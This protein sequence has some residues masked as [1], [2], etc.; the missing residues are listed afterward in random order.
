M[1]NNPLS[2]PKIYCIGSNLESYACLKYL[3]ERDC[4]IHTLITLPSGKAKHVSDYYDLHDY[5]EEHGIATLDTTNVNDEQ[6]IKLLKEQQP[7]F[8]FTFGWS[9]IFKED[10]ISCFSQFIIGTHPSKLPYGRGRAPLPWT[11]LEGL[12]ESAVS[13]FKIDKGVDTGSILSQRTFK[14][15]KGAYVQEL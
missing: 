5:C 6:T 3:V 9:Q 10:F 7:D 2:F 13:F 11:I 12:E 8:L 14:I 15:P 1:Q 4:S